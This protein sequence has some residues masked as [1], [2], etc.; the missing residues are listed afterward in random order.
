[1]T[2]ELVLKALD[3]AYIRSGRPE[4][5]LIH[6]DRG[7]QYC[8]H[9]YRKRIEKYGFVCSMSRKGKEDIPLR[10]GSLQ[11][12]GEEH[13]SCSGALRSCQPLHG[14]EHSFKRHESDIGCIVL[15]N[16]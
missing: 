8:S 2:K 6:S 16:R 9:E 13:D 12:T 14:Q 15:L 5:A 11:G 1:M 10:Q 3:E 7:I 4:G